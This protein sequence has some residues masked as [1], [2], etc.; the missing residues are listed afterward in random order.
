MDSKQLF[1]WARRGVLAVMVINFLFL[2]L[3]AWALE[4]EFFPFILVWLFLKLIFIAT[5]VLTPVTQDNVPGGYQAAFYWFAVAVFN[6]L[7]ISWALEGGLDM[8]LLFLQFGL[9]FVERLLAFYQFRTPG[10]RKAGRR[11]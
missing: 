10:A 6:G 7:I 8:C 9:A 4:S 1:V 3:V 11:S 2:S 5:R